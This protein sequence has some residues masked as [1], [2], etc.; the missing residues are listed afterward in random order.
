MYNVC[1]IYI[2]II[3]ISREMGKI[4]LKR[5]NQPPSPKPKPKTMLTVSLLINVYYRCLYKYIK[6]IIT[7]ETKNRNIILLCN[8][9]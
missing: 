5:A 9:I 3:I 7:L 8:L 6:P 1:K 4:N 2:I